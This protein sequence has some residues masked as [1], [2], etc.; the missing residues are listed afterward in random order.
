METIEFKR[1]GLYIIFGILVLAAVLFFSFHLFSIS[2]Y[3]VDYMNAT[4]LRFT[5][6]SKAT[7]NLC[8]TPSAIYSENVPYL[9]GSCC[10]PMVYGSYA[11]QIEGLKNYPYLSVIPRDPYNVSFSLAKELLDYDSNITLNPEEQAIYNKAMSLSENRGPCCCT[12]WRWYA[13]EGLGKYLITHENFSAA[14]VAHVWDL[15]D[16]CGGSD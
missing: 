9:Q 16:G 6:L 12:C 1:K 15:V 14:Q 11:E 4:Y 3:S 8:S 2:G 13:F 7:T 5:Q 10:D